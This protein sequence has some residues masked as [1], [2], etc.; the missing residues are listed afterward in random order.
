M[1]HFFSR[2]FFSRHFGWTSIILALAVAAIMILVK[3]RFGLSFRT[4]VDI[5]FFTTT[6]LFVLGLLQLWR[7]NRIQQATNIKDFLAEFRKDNSLYSAY[8]D[9]VYSYD[10]DT[11]SEVNKRAQQKLTQIKQQIAAEGIKSEDPEFARRLRLAADFEFI[12]DIQ[13][14]RQEG[15]RLFHPNFFAYSQEERRIDML[16]DYFEAL[17][18]YQY[19]GLISMRDIARILG[20]YL[21]VLVDRK[22]VACYLDFCQN[23]HGWIYGRTSGAA[24]PYPHFGLLRDAFKEYN[25][26]ESTQREIRLLDRTKRE[27]RK[28]LTSQMVQRN[29]ANTRPT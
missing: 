18:F 7:T 29:E 4:D 11:F 20:D 26:K 9:L 22:I 14:T 25:M 27:L 13:Q 12:Q 5:G 2:H 8:F 16:F 24:E 10:D 17:A 28:K 6:P 3:W 1:Q 19:E 21:A 23:P 15:S